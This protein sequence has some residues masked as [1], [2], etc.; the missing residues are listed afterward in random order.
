MT[1]ARAPFAGLAPHADGRPW[2]MGIVNVTPDSFSDGGAAFDPAEAIALGLRLR[3]EGADILDIGGESTRPGSEATPPAEELRRIAP[4]VRALAAAGCVVSI[5]TRRAGVMR[6]ALDAGA[7]IVNDVSALRD[8]PESL[9]LV[10]AR[11]C[12]VVLMHRRGE[13]ATRY[14]GPAYKDVVGEVRDFLAA[15]IGASVA[16]G[17]ARASIAVDPGIGF[18][19]TVAENLALVGCAAA[20]APLGAPVL[21]GASRKGFVGAITGEPAAARR[22]GGSLAAAL[23]AADAGAAIL[24]VHDVRETVQALKARAALLAAR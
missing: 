9:A 4:V 24:R 5:D 3:D 1:A 22:L 18:G 13:A 8:D 20:L 15:R 10:A 14:A 12:P 17:V 7:A 2:V 6:A 16:A 11:G 21:I 23:A 19:K